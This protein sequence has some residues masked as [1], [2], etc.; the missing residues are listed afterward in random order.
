M[1]LRIGDI[2]RV[3]LKDARSLRDDLYAH[4]GFRTHNLM[5]FVTI[6]DG[7]FGVVIRHPVG[8]PVEKLS[9]ITEID[10]VPIK[11]EERSV[12]RPLR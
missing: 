11:A 1:R 7:T 6:I 12:I 3:R 8:A 4:G 5:A 2:P 9:H 10:G